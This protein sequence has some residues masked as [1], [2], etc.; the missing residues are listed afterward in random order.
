M[1]SKRV[2]RELNKIYKKFAE[3]KLGNRK[4]ATPYRMNDDPQSG[5]AFQ[6]K[7]SPEVITETAI[8]LANHEGVDLSTLSD[9]QIRQFL[10]AHKLGIDCSGFA[11]RLLDFVSKKIFKKNLQEA[12]GLDHVGNTNVELLTSTDFSVP[13]DKISDIKPADLIKVHS[14]EKP[15]HVIVVLEVKKKQIIYAHS[16]ASSTPTGVHTSFIKITDSTKPLAQQQWAEQYLLRNWNHKLGDG[17]HR[18]KG[19]AFS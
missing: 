14:A 15:S 7:S 18:L 10:E 13:V 6:G 17:V 2:T 9:E 12:T 11:Y 5:P 19:L 8:N 16:S 4:V 3:L 1:D